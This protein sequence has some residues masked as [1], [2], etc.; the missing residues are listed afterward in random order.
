M[1]SRRTLPLVAAPLALTLALCACTVAETVCLFPAYSSWGEVVESA[2]LVVVGTVISVA[3]V[4]AG[5]AR[6]GEQIEV[7]MPGTKS[8]PAAGIRPLGEIDANALVLA[9]A[10]FPGRPCSPLTPTQAVF[11]IGDDGTVLEPNGDAGFLP[12]DL[13]WLEG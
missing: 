9:L 8:A 6:Q 1:D 2:D 5:D 4:I 3:A 7:S 11:G 13:N 10:A 12:S